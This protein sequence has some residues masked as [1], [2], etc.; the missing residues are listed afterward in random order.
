MKKI[1]CL[2]LIILI[3]VPLTKVLSQYNQT[4]LISLTI[5]NVEALTDTE[6]CTLFCLGIGSLDCPYS[7]DKVKYIQ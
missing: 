3:I 7:K 5:N 2:I 1:I 4:G 6:N